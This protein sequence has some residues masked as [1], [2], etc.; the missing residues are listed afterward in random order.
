MEEQRQGGTDSIVKSF[1]SFE[2]L[3]QIKP[4]VKRR[5]KRKVWV[6]LAE[7]LIGKTR[8]QQARLFLEEANISAIAF[9]D[10]ETCEMVIYNYALMAY[11]TADWGRV[12]C[13]LD[14]V[15]HVPNQQ[16]FWLKKISLLVD[17]LHNISRPSITFQIQVNNIGFE[18]AKTVLENAV[19]TVKELM[20][21]QP[22]SAYL[23][24]YLKAKLL[25]KL[26]MLYY[27][28][29]KE[30]VRH[31]TQETK[32]QLLETAQGYLTESFD[33]LSR[34]GYKVES[35][36]IGCVLIELRTKLASLQDTREKKKSYLVETFKMALKAVQD[37]SAHL[38]DVTMMSPAQEAGN[39]F[40]PMQ[41]VL[42]N[43]RKHCA[44]VMYEITCVAS[45]EKKERRLKEECK[46]AIERVSGW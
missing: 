23:A 25:F 21:R 9:S 46:L 28:E 16:L 36:G 14:T 19:D 24:P 29:S 15:R 5:T 12:V 6:R 13:L 31:R 40:L 2:S 22:N 45:E 39:I 8:Y 10:T 32:T 3:Y 1:T 30:E 38:N 35:I 44:D 26:A 43:A 37:L 20:Q 27:T 4:I 42:M 17:A 33:L 7:Y 34:L 41:R 18:K 11:Q